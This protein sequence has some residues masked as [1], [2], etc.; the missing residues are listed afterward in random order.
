ML[1]TPKL[2]LHPLKEIELK[3]GGRTLVIEELK[4][5]TV[6]IYQQ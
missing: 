1:D 3:Y 6:I 2:A 5:Y 4:L